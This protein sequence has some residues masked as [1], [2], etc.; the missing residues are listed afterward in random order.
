[1]DLGI[2]L[3][4]FMYLVSN[5]IAFYNLKELT[6]TFTPSYFFSSIIY[7]ITYA[8]FIILLLFM[9]YCNY[10]MTTN[11]DSWDFWMLTIWF[12]AGL[13]CVILSYI[14]LLVPNMFKIIGGFCLAMFVVAIGFEFIKDSNKKILNF[15]TPVLSIALW[16]SA[17]IPYV[18]GIPTASIYTD[19][20]WFGYFI[21]NCILAS[22]L[23][24]ILIVGVVSLIFNILMNK[25]E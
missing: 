14:L 20:S 19:Q 3:N 4:I 17:V 8:Q 18:V 2:F 12:I 21:Y 11:N 15:V 5:T 1:M 23:L 6:Y 16:V 7:E 25:F 13:A 24:I 9:I 10:F 22:A